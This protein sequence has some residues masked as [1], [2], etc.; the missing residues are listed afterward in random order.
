MSK[1]ANSLNFREFGLRIES[2]LVKP[3]DK[4]FSPPKVAS[5]PTLACHAKCRR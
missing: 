3:T 2:A 4:Y 5:T 1:S